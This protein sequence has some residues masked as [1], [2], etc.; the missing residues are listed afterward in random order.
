MDSKKI[1]SLS[2]V[3][4]FKVYGE[5]KKGKFKMPFS[6]LVKALKVN[7]ALEK[8]YCEFGS[9]HK[10]KRFEVKIIKVEQED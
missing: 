8:I 6:K 7:D 10:A 1:N 4:N 2:E 9:R 3:K 5:I